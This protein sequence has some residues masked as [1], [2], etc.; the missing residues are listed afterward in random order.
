MADEEQGR[1]TY[2]F[3]LQTQLIQKPTQCHGGYLK[4]RHASPPEIEMGTKSLVDMIIQVLKDMEKPTP[5]L[6]C[7]PMS[8]LMSAIPLRLIDAREDHLR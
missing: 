8:Q 2:H 7:T 5:P 3:P 1:N 4:G 6:T